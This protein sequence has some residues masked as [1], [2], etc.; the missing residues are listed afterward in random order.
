MKSRFLVAAKA[1]FG[2][3]VLRVVR[4]PWDRRHD[5]KGRATSAA[6]T[7][8][9]AFNSWVVPRDIFRGP[10]RRYLRRSYEARESMICRVCASNERVRQISKCLIDTVRAR[11]RSNDRRARTAGQ[12][13]GTRRG[14]DQRHRERRLA[15][16]LPRPATEARLL[17]VPGGRSARPGCRRRTKRGHVSADVPGRFVRSR[18]E[19]GLPRTRPRLPRSRCSKCVRVVRPG[20]RVILTVPIEA[21]SHTPAR[22]LASATAGPSR[23]SRLP[24]TTD[25]AEGFSD[26]CQSVATCWPSRNSVPTSP[27]CW[28]WRGFGPKLFVTKMIVPVRPGS[29]T[30]SSLSEPGLAVAGNPGMRAWF[31]RL[32]VD[33]RSQQ[34]PQGNRA[35]RLGWVEHGRGSQTG[36]RMG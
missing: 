22:V 27:L 12:F 23:I 36:R 15:A 1:R 29:C 5:K 28:R 2:G 35:R 24:S 20:G 21:R 4:P 14:R 32:A 17:R 16:S 6:R 34:T 18:F 33:G 26:W 9:F 7:G 30:G 13:S 11:P 19:F 31:D 25:G 10:D 3:L 8:R